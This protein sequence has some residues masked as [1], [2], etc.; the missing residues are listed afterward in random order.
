M[1]NADHVRSATIASLNARLLPR[2]LH[3]TALQLQLLQRFQEIY[4]PRRKAV[5]QPLDTDLSDLPSWEWLIP[6]LRVAHIDPVLND[7]VLALVLGSIGQLD[8]NEE[9]LR[10]GASLHRRAFGLLKSRLL[11]AD[12]R[13]S[14]YTLGAVAVFGV[15]EVSVLPVRT[16]FQLPSLTVVNRYSW[17]VRPKVGWHI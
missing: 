13:L 16:L 9:Y 8:C 11:N 7:V 12:Q 2:A 5:G 1:L 14:D 10:M 15:Y 4:A 6:S 17:A 3:G